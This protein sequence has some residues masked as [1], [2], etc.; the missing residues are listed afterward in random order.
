ML[1]SRLILSN[2]LGSEEQKQVMTWILVLALPRATRGNVRKLISLG[3]TFLVN[4]NGALDWTSSYIRIKGDF[5]V[6]T[7]SPT[8]NDSD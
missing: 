5:K 4:T 8:V 2:I 3:L 1:L 6:N 7:S